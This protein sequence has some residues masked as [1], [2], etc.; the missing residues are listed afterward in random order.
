MLIA[1]IRVRIMGAV[2][3]ST[4]CELCANPKAD[5]IQNRVYMCANCYLN[6]FAK[7]ERPPISFGGNGKPKKGGDSRK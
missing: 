3:M 4:K 7:N 6:K 1:S 2:G 5:I